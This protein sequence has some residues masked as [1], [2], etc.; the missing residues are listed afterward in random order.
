LKLREEDQGYLL[1][2]EV[3]LKAKEGGLDCA[4]E[5][6]GDNECWRGIGGEGGAQSE[7]LLLA[8]VGQVWVS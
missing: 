7:A 6:G 5:R 3:G 1:R 4:F 2:S 8:Q